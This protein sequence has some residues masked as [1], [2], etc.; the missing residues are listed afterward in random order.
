MKTEQCERGVS[1]DLSSDLCCLFKI[2]NKKQNGCLSAISSTL[3]AST[4]IQFDICLLQY[5][6]KH[7]PA[8]HFAAI[9]E[10]LTILLVQCQ[11][12]M[13]A[14]IDQSNNVSNPNGDEMCF[15]FMKMRRTIQDVAIDFVSMI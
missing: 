2:A 3:L 10:F 13:M 7:L 5:Y 4:S 14:S 1:F 15:S 11:S 8:F 12:I 9:K 6:I